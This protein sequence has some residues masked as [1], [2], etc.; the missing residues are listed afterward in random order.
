MLLK[1][2]IIVYTSYMSN[3]RPLIEE[4]RHAVSF[5]DDDDNNKQIKLQFL[6]NLAKYFLSKGY[7]VIYGAEEFDKDDKES[8][9]LIAKKN[10]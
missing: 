7:G 10:N 5:Y 9:T 3:T 6:H 1:D 4:Y 2:V 8:Y